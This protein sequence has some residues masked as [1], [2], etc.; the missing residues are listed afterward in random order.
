MSGHVKGDTP[1]SP[2]IV[3]DHHPY[4]GP[5]THNFLV[6][7]LEIPLRKPWTTT[8]SYTPFL[9]RALNPHRSQGRRGGFT[10]GITRYR[11]WA[12]PRTALTRNRQGATPRDTPARDRLTAPPRAI[13]LALGRW[14]SSGDCASLV[15][16]VALPDRLWSRAHPS[17][18]QT[19]WSTNPPTSWHRLFCLTEVSTILTLNLFHPLHYLVTATLPHGEPTPTARNSVKR[20]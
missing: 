19:F 18:F 6:P 4:S 14:S 20:R 16:A 2:F 15:V 11:R 3:F 5:G 7:D 8:L 10:E 17:V 1:Q 9:L 12:T 13:L